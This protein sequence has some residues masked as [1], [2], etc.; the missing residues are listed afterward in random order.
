MW[1]KLEEATRR[2]ISF[3][4]EE[5]EALGENYVSTEHLILGLIRESNHRA[6]QVLAIMGISLTTIRAEVMRQVTKGDGRLPKDMALTPRAKRVI[7]LA[8]EEAKQEPESPSGGAPVR[9]DHLLLGLI[10][11]GEG[12]AA[13]VLTKLGATIQKIREA[14]TYLDAPA[15]PATSNSE[16]ASR[17]QVSANAIQAIL[18]REV[19]ILHCLKLQ[20][21]YKEGQVCQICDLESERPICIVRVTNVTHMPV[22]D[23]SRKVV[24]GV[25]YPSRQAIKADLAL[26]H[27]VENVRNNDPAVTLTL[28]LVMVIRPQYM[29]VEC[30]LPANMRLAVAGDDLVFSVP[31]GYR[32]FHT[33]GYCVQ[34]FKIP[35]L[36]APLVVSVTLWVEFAPNE[37]ECGRYHSVQAGLAHGWVR[38][39]PRSSS[40]YLHINAPDLG[41]A[42]VLYEAIMRGDVA[43]NGGSL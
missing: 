5:A 11:E 10:L 40:V 30:Y 17:I 35:S 32:Q 14:I 42:C 23:L 9:T 21:E 15:H 24:G 25:Q 18:R 29:D 8:Y 27:S 20:D 36:L 31:V 3:A 2:A 33:E 6:A 1:N 22:Q 34:N 12:L 41:S 38:T 16:N 26:R 39:T 37:L 7:D 13:R 4:Q 19:T 28:R 43:V